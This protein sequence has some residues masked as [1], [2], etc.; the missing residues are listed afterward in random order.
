MKRWNVLTFVAW[1][2][3][4]LAAARLLALP[5]PSPPTAIPSPTGEE[6]VPPTIASLKNLKQIG[7]ALVMYVQDYDDV[8]PKMMTPGVAKNKLLPYAHNEM[9]FVYP[10]THKMYQT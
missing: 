10:G 2:C 8:L 1:S 7:L 9:V 6:R 4:V 5:A 3:A